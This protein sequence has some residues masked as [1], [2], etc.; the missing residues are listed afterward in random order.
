MLDFENPDLITLTKAITPAI[1]RIG[2]SPQDSVVYNISGECN[3]KYGIPGYGC[4]QTTNSEYYGCINKTRWDQ[5]NAFAQATGV[6]LLYG[7]NACYGRKSS[8]SNMNLS[9]AQNLVDY[10]NSL[11]D[12]VGVFG[13]E[14]GNEIDGHIDNDKYS[15]DFY[16]L[17]KIMNGKYKM[18]GTDNGLGSYITDLIKNLNNVSSSLNASDILYRLTYHHYPNCGYPGSNTVFDLNCLESSKNEAAECY[19]NY[20]EPNGIKCMMGMSLFILI[21][22]IIRG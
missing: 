6:E 11:G 19:Q 7:L 9:N 21:Y 22:T 1:L 10:T 8:S 12:K 18:I 16:N 17:Y 13:F 4:S 2:G 14:L 3:E 20:G 5:I 15:E